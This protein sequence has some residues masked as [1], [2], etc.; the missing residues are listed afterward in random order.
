MV[1]DLLARLAEVVG[2]HVTGFALLRSALR[3]QEPVLDVMALLI[4]REQLSL[5]VL[6]IALQPALFELVLG[7][8]ADALHNVELDLDQLVVQ[9]VQLRLSNHCLK[10]YR[11]FCEKV[12][13]GRRE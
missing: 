4:L 8:A 7:I 2:S 6:D 10:I 9:L 13:R 5:L 12:R 3:A 11:L 1:L